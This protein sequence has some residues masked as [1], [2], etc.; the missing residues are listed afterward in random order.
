MD[1]AARRID[2]PL[3]SKLIETD[4]EIATF[5]FRIA[6]VD[7]E[8][9]GM[10]SAEEQLNLGTRLVELGVELQTRSRMLR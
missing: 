3:V 10:P 7:I 6:G 2:R 4:Q 8:L 1:D 5:I 9:A